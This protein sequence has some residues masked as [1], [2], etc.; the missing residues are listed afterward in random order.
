MSSLA[1][2]FIVRILKQAA[3]AEGETTPGLEASNKKCPKQSG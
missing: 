2:R 1:A 3:S